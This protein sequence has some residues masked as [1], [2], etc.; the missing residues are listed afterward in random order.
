MAAKDNREEQNKKEAQ[1]QTEPQDEAQ[2][3]A[4]ANDRG[5]TYT[6]GEAGVNNIARLHALS[7][8]RAAGENFDPLKLTS[9]TAE[10]KAAGYRGYSPTGPGENDAPFSENQGVLLAFDEP[11]GADP[12]ALG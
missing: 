11:E 1:P 5:F 2:G 9:N 4:S 7:R 3:Q 10:A 8:M 6:P 12:D